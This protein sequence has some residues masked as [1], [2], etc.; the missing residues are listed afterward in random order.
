MMT[1]ALYKNVIM[2]GA[3]LFL[4]L[5]TGFISKLFS[6]LTKDFK[7]LESS[8]LLLLV[9]PNDRLGCEPAWFDCANKAKG[10]QLV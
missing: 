10:G 2:K 6:N 9:V 8:L 3:V 1:N 4:S 7:A 5:V